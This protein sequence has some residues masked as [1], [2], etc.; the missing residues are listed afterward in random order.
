VAYLIAADLVLLI[1]VLFVA[2]VVVGL[3]LIL[4]GGPFAWSWV[5]NPWFRLAHLAA[6]GIVVLQSWLGVI[7]PLTIWE[8]ALREK[9]GDAVYSGSFVA[10]WLETLLYYE[11]PAWVFVVAYTAFGALV[12]LSWFR[13]RPRRFASHPSRLRSQR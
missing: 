13:V 11:A 5:R 8:M 4:I 6:I 1:H 3:L 9:A 12:V 7:C 2:F 10:H